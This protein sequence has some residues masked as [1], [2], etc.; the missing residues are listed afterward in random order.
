[1]KAA[2]IAAVLLVALVAIV[3]LADAG[4][5]SAPFCSSCHEMGP[6]TA[7]WR[8]SPHAAVQC[9]KC[10][11]APYEWYEYPEALVMRAGLITKDLGAHLKNRVTSAD[12]DAARVRPMADKVCLQCHDVNRKATSGFRILIDHPAHAK[13]NK[14]CISCHI[15]TAHPTPERGT[16]LSFM[17][18]CFKCHGAKSQPK[19]SAECRVCHPGGYELKP[20][21][22]KAKRWAKAHGGIAIKDRQQ[23]TMCHKQSFCD[24]CHGMVM[25]HPAKWAQGRNG[26]AATAQRDRKLCE[27]CHV[28]KPDLC[29][30][31]HHKAYDPEK[32]DWVK[33]HTFEVDRKGAAYCL[34][35][36]SPVYCSRCHVRTAIAIS[37]Q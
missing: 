12:V 37:N 24:D 25:P 16:A 20:A 10:H 17:A 23:C 7:A 36:H 33:Q 28:E 9:V 22:H 30:M 5:S 19:A 35:C 2:R 11:V 32:G 15:T 31:C 26:H 1:M 14:Q 8:E 3:A 18:Q 4:T 34:D 13:R 21:S 29:S 6:R 27:R